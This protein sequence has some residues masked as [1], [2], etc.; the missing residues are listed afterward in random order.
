MRLSEIAVVVGG[1]L[2]GDDAEVTGPAFLDSRAPE[3]GGLF[4]AFA[5]EQADGHTFAADAVAGG[6]AA[7]LGTRATAVSTVV[8][9]DTRRA[10]QDLAKH[11]L[12][13]RR[14][15]R[16]PLRVVAITGST[17]KTSAKDMLATVLADG[18]PTVATHGSFNNE[19]GLPLTVLRVEDLTRYLV[20]EMG[21]RGIGH[22]AQLCA[23][24]PPDVSLVLNVGKA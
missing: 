8:V 3:P 6:A 9:N 18:G 12:A 2:D 5:G 24:A 16:T 15:M 20:L 1:Q 23:I 21:A 11:V 7:V 22:L 14:E 4:A 10:L 13:R 17:G 19:L